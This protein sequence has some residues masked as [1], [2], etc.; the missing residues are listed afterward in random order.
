M[1]DR[2]MADVLFRQLKKVPRELR[3]LIYAFVL[4]QPTE[5]IIPAQPRQELETAIKAMT[6]QEAK[7][8]F[9]MPKPSLLNVCRQIRDEATP[10]YYA[11]NTFRAIISADHSWSLP[12]CWIATLTNREK[13]IVSG[14]VI[15]FRM[16]DTTIQKFQ[17][18][19]D[20]LL[21]SGD[22]IIADPVAALGRFLA[23]V[24]T[25]INFDVLVAMTSEME[26][27]DDAAAFDLAK[28]RFVAGQTGSHFDPASAEWKKMMEERLRL[29]KARHR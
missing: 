27:I 1:A 2:D 23:G 3:D 16:S 7:Q 10:I 15:E 20:T 18:V 6:S 4:H 17:D 5:I 24:K 19:M 12:F 22:A 8:T 21:T 9:L 26:R 11:T 13:K 28:I 29:V 14:L 25:C